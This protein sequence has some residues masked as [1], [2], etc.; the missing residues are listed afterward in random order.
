MTAAR[1]NT[2]RATQDAASTGQ[3]DTL[4]TQDPTCVT[5][6]GAATPTVQDTAPTKHDATPSIQNSSPSKHDTT[7]TTHVS[8]PVERDDISAKEEVTAL[9]QGSATKKLEK[10]LQDLALKDEHDFVRVDHVKL[11]EPEELEDDWEMLEEYP[12]DAEWVEI[13]HEAAKKA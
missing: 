8:A 9:E 6:D 4:T 5:Q 12:E 2:T 1:R 11:V 13:T 10:A 7:P 3:I